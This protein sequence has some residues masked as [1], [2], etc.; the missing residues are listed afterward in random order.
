MFF[1]R[2][3][4][5]LENYSFKNDNRTHKT[6]IKHGRA[7]LICLTDTVKSCNL[8]MVTTLL[9]RYTLQPKV[10]LSVK[11]QKIDQYS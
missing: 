9:K 3:V 8:T 7:E 1:A 2:K 10:T 6:H 5:E 4:Q 11:Q